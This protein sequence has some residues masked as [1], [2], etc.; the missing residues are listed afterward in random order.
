MSKNSLDE[1]S[2]GLALTQDA[3]Y[4]A[5]N[6]TEDVLGAQD[7]IEEEIEPTVNN[8]TICGLDSE[9]SQQ[10]RDAHDELKTYVKELGSMLEETLGGFSNDI[11]T[12]ISI[13]EDIDSQL[14]TAEILFWVL[15]SVSILLIGL[16]LAMM[17][18]VVFAWREKSNGFTKCIQYAVVW[19]LFILLLVSI[20]LK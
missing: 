20:C 7:D 6:L 15:V 10:I 3:A 8:G 18:G 17:V 16:V 12:L 9:T 14:E 19:P 2:R 11:R 4:K 1:V 5:L 13:T